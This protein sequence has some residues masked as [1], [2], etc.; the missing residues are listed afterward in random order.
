MWCFRFRFSNLNKDV[1]TSGRNK[2]YWSWWKSTVVRQVQRLTRR[3]HSDYTGHTHS[4]QRERTSPVPKKDRSQVTK[5]LWDTLALLMSEARNP[6]A[7][8]H[9]LHPGMTDSQPTA[10]FTS[11]ATDTGSAA[12]PA[13]HRHSRSAAPIKIKETTPHRGFA[14]SEHGCILTPWREINARSRC[15]RPDITGAALPKMT[16]EK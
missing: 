3:K 13:E 6:S 8:H 5:E 2:L 4:Q 1:K 15:R 14:W 7:S 10:L 9:V 16:Q 12:W 11:S